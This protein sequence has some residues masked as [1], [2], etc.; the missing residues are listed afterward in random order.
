VLSGELAYELGDKVFDMKAGDAIFFDGNIAHV[1]KNTTHN[2]VMLLVLYLYT[3][4]NL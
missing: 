2:T 1:P 3:E 4:H